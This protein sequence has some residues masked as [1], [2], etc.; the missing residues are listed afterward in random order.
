MHEAVKAALHA[1]KTDDENIT[2]AEAA[3]NA[4]KAENADI[5][6][7]QAVLLEAARLNPALAPGQWR[8]ATREA[9]IAP[10]GERPRIVRQDSVLMVSTM[11]ALRDRRAIE[12]PNQFRLGRKP[13]AADLTFG[14]GTHA[15]LGKHLA[16][17]QITEVFMILLSQA[18]LRRPKW[19]LSWWRGIRWV[20]P[21]PRWFDMEFD[22]AIS[23]A[24]QT[25]ITICAPL[26][27]RT[28]RRD[29]EEK[30]A[31]LGNPATK[32]M[33]DML[34]KTCIVHFASLSL[35]EAGD[36]EKP[37]PHLLLELNV[38][39][40]ADAA[41]RSIADADAAAGNELGSIFSNTPL[42]GAPLT[43]ILHRHVLD[44]ETRPWGATGLTFEGTSGFSVPDIQ[45]QDALATCANDALRDFMHDNPGA[46][47]RA[48]SALTF[49]RD[50]IYR[51]KLPSGTDVGMYTDHGRADMPPRRDVN[52]ADFLIVPC[53]KRLP[54]SK[55]KERSRWEALAGFLKTKAFWRLFIPMIVITL[56]LGAVVFCALSATTSIGVY[57]RFVLAVT[58]GVAA[59]LLLLGL[60]AAAFLWLLRRYENKDI[61]D[62]RNPELEQIRKIASVED[63]PGFAHNHFMAVTAL[64]TGWF[65]KLT[66]AL[67]LWGIKQSVTHLF[68]PG[69]VL[70]MGTI[71]YAKWFRLPG[72]DKL[73]FQANYDGSWESYLEDFIMK[74]HEGQTAAWSNGVGFPR[75]KWLV[76]EGAQDGDRF[77]RWVR[78]QQVIA[79]FWYSRFPHLTT[80][81]IRNNA[82][83]HDGLARATTDTAA[84]AWLD[85]FGSMPR[86]DHAI[87]TEEVQ[88]LVFRGQRTLPYAVYALIQL[89]DERAVRSKWLKE[90]VLA[91]KHK[92]DGGTPVYSDY[93]SVT[94]GDHPY[95]SN[96]DLRDNATYVAFTA[97]GLAKLGISQ[98]KPGDGLATFPNTFN[99][100]MANRSGIL[101]DSGKSAPE[102]WRWTDSNWA[103]DARTSQPRAA[104][105]IVLIYAKSP[106]ECEQMLSYHVVAL[107]GKQSV[108]HAVYTKP[109]VDRIKY[110]K[111][112]RGASA[113]PVDE[114]DQ[115]KAAK[116]ATDLDYEH[117]GFHDGI[118]QPVI[119]GTQRSSK[120]FWQRDIVE[121]GEFILGYRN[122]QKYYPPTATVSTETDPASRHLP[123]PLTDIPS[124]FPSFENSDTARDFGRNGSFLVVRQLAQ[125]VK[126]FEDFIKEKALELEK[127]YPNLGDVV[128]APINSK[129]VAARMMGRWPDGTPLVVR[130]GADMGEHPRKHDMRD[131][132]FS[133]GTDD[134][135]GLHCPFGAHIR[136]ANPRDSMQ[137]EDPAQQPITNRH[138]LLRRGR[139]YDYEP[140][141]KNE[142]EK[143]LFFTCL[144][145][146]LDRQFEFVQQTW[147]GSPSF[148]GLRDEVDPIAA[149]QDPKKNI[150]T[151][152]TPAGPVRMRG[153]KSFV[154]VVAGGYFFLP[155][156]SAIQY[157]ADLNR[158]S[159]P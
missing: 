43:D 48:M 101:G 99:L 146:D 28:D 128:G 54:I 15:C 71:H 109:A 4:R 35:I 70:N 132:D 78:R 125:D 27:E 121:P 139:T 103:E 44:L 126:G 51:G 80:D 93:C 52:F 73:I 67:S 45:V 62:D 158:N 123:T 131:N 143:G 159:S 76:Q 157:L 20:G 106:E 46:G 25:M 69:F 12:F 11:S 111:S 82:L 53:R 86:P 10:D 89:P 47:R 38:D 85:C 66:L 92:S 151:I 105:G 144:C 138:R 58:G 33:R 118:S 55:W 49:V 100:G 9:V 154:T 155:S 81:Q 65:R 87:E 136:R 57:G 13:Y 19:S 7:L 124:R 3:K 16:M 22:P 23:P 116:L 129:W 134:P 108:I 8:Y 64:K 149:W 63:A 36:A 42:A 17:A 104:D 30:I 107:G 6:P 113:P 83:I 14:D 75:T 2:T 74:A 56:M 98:G 77:K 40:P 59:S 137:P 50:R 84:R 21:F 120:G 96:P 122:N 88:S 152:P 110:E 37:A 97:A 140:P 72:R 34:D 147:I 141:G 24:T 115:E 117:F 26:G 60:I 150:F 61:P 29:V 31:R 112:G 127:D 119:R 91:G 148:H 102:N 135:Q 90:L 68:R 156:R 41:I 130:P 94:F 142:N 32:A 1:R 95:S 18:K 39:G 145:T 153:M 5:A 114:S 133:Y 79:Q